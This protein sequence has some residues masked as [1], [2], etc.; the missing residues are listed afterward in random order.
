MKDDKALAIFQ[1]ALRRTVDGEL[2]WQQ[3]TGSGMEDVFECSTPGGFTLKAYPHTEYN[4]SA[5]E[6]PPS[7]TLFDATEQMV[8]DI[9]SLLEGVT[10]VDLRRLYRA[11][12]RI[13]LGIDDKLDLILKDLEAMPKDSH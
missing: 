11:A 5:G 8:F 10:E 12:R 7:L 2:S 13:G 3:S 6:G 1:L 9:T 4:T